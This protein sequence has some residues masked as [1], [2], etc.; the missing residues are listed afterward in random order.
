MDVS[1][2]TIICLFLLNAFSTAAWMIHSQKL[3]NK[4]MSRDFHEYQVAEGVTQ[5]R[6]QKPPL[7]EEDLYEVNDF[8]PLNDLLKLKTN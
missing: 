5:E 3:V 2:I 1:I 7:K 4:L 8:G 6:K